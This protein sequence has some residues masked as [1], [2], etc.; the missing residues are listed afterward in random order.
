M[1]ALIR[2]ALL[3][4]SAFLLVTGCGAIESRTGAILP[5]NEAPSVLDQCTRDVPL[6]ADG[7]WQPSRK[8]VEQLELVLPGVV[9]SALAGRTGSSDRLGSDEYRRQYVGVVSDGRQLIYINGLHRSWIEE[10]L[11]YWGRRAVSVCDGGL[12]FWG[13]VYDVRSREIGQV[14][15]N[16]RLA[17]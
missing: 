10:R 5:P 4:P 3:A 9:D 11:P 8:E 16:T 2:Q 14:R 12:H 17:N 7:Y 15:F 6:R 1:H 13:A